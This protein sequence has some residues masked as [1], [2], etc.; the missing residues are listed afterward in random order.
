[1]KEQWIHLQHLAQGDYRLKLESCGKAN[2][3]VIR[4]QGSES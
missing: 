4:R 2:H 3:R 1:M